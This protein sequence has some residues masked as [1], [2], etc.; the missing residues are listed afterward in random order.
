V[1]CLL[2]VPDKFKGTATAGAVAAAM[3]A[4]ARACGWAATELPMSDGGEGLLEVM[5]GANR[6]TVVRGPLGAAVTA[7]WRFE[8]EASD[9]S[10]PATAV[11]EMSQAAGLVLAGGRR[12]NDAVAASTIGV[13]ELILSA[14][15]AGAR[16]LVV[17]CG[18]SATTDGGC[19]AL[20]VLKGAE[21]LAGAEMIVACD[22]K[23]GFVQAAERFAPQKGASPA[24][25][26]LL[27][28]RLGE[29]ADRYEGSFGLD[30]RHL[31]G[32]GAAGGLAGGLAAI[33]GALVSGFELVASFL[34]LGDRMA[35]ADAVAT[36]EGSLDDQSFDGKVVGGI[37]PRRGDLP[38]LCVAGGA[39]VEGR[40]AAAALGLDV[41][42]L[43][44]RYG[45]GEAMARP[46]EL[47]ADVVAQ[48]LGSL[49]S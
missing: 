40:R 25:V 33:G 28:R 49:P 17:G 19:G 38:V 30:V 7:S 46:L 3:A 9:G 41:V 45:A 43:S 44:E 31:E 16:R 22:V 15:A 2:A 4:G 23:A 47:V 26:A 32:A 14:V 27:E 18:G 21:A 6:R 35:A 29:L 11:I 20:S 24:Q 37:A 36:G 5:G 10:A 42:S 12:H 34:G 13:G 39:T 1:P 48:W 8:E